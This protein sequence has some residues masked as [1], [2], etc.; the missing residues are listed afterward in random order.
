MLL[1]SFL[2]SQ[3]KAEINFQ[4]VEI[5]SENGSLD[6]TLEITMEYTLN[7]TRYAPAFN[8]G[9][10]GPTLRV[11][12]GDML[13]VTLQNNLDTSAP[14]DLELLQ[15]IQ[16][17]QNEENDPI[18]VTIIYNRLS[19]IGNLYEPEYG[20]WGLNL[21]NIHFHG[22]GFP[23]LKEDLQ[24]PVDGGQSKTFEYQI[25]N[26]HP[27]GLTWYHSHF[28]GNGEH[29]FMSGLFGFMVIEGTDN[30]VTVVPE[31]GNATE[32]FLLYVLQ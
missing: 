15:Y 16:D 4:A 28:H 11:K 1:C 26:D 8:G 13:R 7:G 30:D 9:P 3:S 6:V 19:S 29:A 31:I 24:H 12:P 10:I 32:I 17:P 25:P 5:V 18:N 27:P 20:F 21:Q 2:L 22:A 14:R 23:P